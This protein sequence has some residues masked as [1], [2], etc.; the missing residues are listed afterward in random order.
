MIFL[1]NDYSS[2]CHPK[3][4]EALTVTNMENTEG[5]GLDPYCAK[6]AQDIK[7]IIDCQNVDVHFL[8]A[9]TQTNLT[10][11]AS[12]L[13][14]HEAIIAPYTGHICCHE[15]GAIEATGHKIIHVPSKDG[16]LTSADIEAVMEEH[17]DAHYVK[18][19]LIFISN[20]TE[21]G[22]I[23]S[24]SELLE[25]RETCDKH[26]LLIYMD[27]A[28]LAMALTQKDNDLDIT[29]IPKI[30]DM[31]YIGGTK[32]GIM[33]GEALVIVND[34][35]KVDT[36]CL[37]KQRGAVLA[38][39]RLLGVQFSEIFKDNLYFKLGKHANQLA[40]KLAEG[41]KAKGY[42]FENQPCS[43]LVFPIFPDSLIAELEKKVMMEPNFSNHDGTSS[44]RLVTS[45]SSTEDDVNSFLELI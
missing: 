17:C 1:R 23:Y 30:V 6:A 15:A 7:D 41:I 19:R 2:G 20:L 26:N 34:A 16:K 18:P 29:D 32:C 36:R 27:G 10:A 8:M 28:R 5:Y 38:K 14:P 35:L 9:G 4:L 3:V 12:V 39:G 24:K 45:W 22:I 11:L 40:Y 21:T 31:F 13:R 33:F 44:V 42:K 43:N 25:L 37:M